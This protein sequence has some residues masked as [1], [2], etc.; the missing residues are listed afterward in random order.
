MTTDPRSLIDALEEQR[1]R[2]VALALSVPADLRQTQFV[3][4]WSLHE[5]IAHLIGWDR[6][7]INTV[8]DLLAGRLPPFYDRYEPNWVGYNDELVAKHGDEDW[9]ALMQELSESQTAALLKLRSLSAKQLTQPGPVWR[10]RPVTIAGVLR[11]ATKDEYEHLGQIEALVAG[12][13]SQR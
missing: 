6:T 3:G 8:D 11:F 4:K 9:D 12:A 13:G 1:E 7:N 2:L 10:T 5:V